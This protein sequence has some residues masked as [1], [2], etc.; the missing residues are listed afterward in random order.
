MFKDQ[1]EEL[2]A[3]FDQALADLDPATLRHYPHKLKGSSQ[4]LGANLL[5]EKCQQLQKLAER[6]DFAAKEAGETIVAVKAQ[7]A[8][9]VTAVN[10]NFGI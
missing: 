3:G 5:A 7:Y 9:W 4:S 2:L 1:A 10:D 6:E 8:T